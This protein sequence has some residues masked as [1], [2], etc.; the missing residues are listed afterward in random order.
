MYKSKKVNTKQ[1]KAKSKWVN[2]Y[3]TFNKDDVHSL[4][5]NIALINLTFV[6]EI[7]TYKC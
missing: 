4:L 3:I 1:L 2:F 5:I 6:G 7:E